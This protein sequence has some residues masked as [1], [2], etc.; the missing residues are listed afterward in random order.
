MELKCDGLMK[1]LYFPKLLINNYFKITFLLERREWHL[2][3]LL[4]KRTG[5]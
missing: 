5:L 3:L 2:G 4:K 1:K